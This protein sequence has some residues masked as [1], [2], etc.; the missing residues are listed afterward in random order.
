V[1]FPVESSPVER[2]RLDVG[3]VVVVDDVDH[4]THDGLPIDG[5]ATCRFFFVVQSVFVKILTVFC[6]ANFIKLFLLIQ[7]LPFLEDFPWDNL[8]SKTF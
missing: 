6:S 3:E 2:E 4:R 8:N 7:L 5:N 1:K